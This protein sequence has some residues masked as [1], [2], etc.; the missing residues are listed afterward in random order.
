MMRSKATALVMTAALV[1][2]CTDRIIMDADGVSDDDVP[3]DEDEPPADDDDPPPDDD[4]E[5][6]PPDDD[7]EPPPSGCVDQ[8]IDA[9]ALPVSLGGDFVIGESRYQPSCVGSESSEVT[10]SFTAPRA[11]TYL[12]DTNDST[13]DTVLYALGPNCEPPELSC[14]DD[15]NGTIFAE[16]GLGMAQGQT[17]VIVLDSFGAQGRWSLQVR[18]GGRCPDLE[19]ESLPELSVQGVLDRA[20]EDNSVV[21]SCSDSGGADVVYAWTPP[22]TGQWQITTIGSAFDTVLSVYQEGCQA[23]LACNDDFDGGYTSTVF[24]ELEE[25][26]PVVIAVDSYADEAGAYSL[27]VFPS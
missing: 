18:E 17:A 10:F 23:E 19:L 3:E 22:F 2:G 20:V 13:F 16:L 24:V 21:P 8:V 7:D 9:G 25:G 27:S 12:F 15:A 1:A 5:P 6:P 11:A 4:G 14:N 26:V